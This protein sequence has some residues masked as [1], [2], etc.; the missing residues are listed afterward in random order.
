M[1][2]SL[3]PVPDR[4]TAELMGAFYDHLGRGEPIIRA[5]AMAKRDLATRNPP[6]TWAAFQLVSQSFIPSA[7]N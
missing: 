3:S 2:A 5:L 4:V 6:A 7:S 1:V